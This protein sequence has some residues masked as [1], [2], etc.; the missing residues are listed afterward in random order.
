MTRTEGRSCLFVFFFLSFPL[1]QD[2]YV[3]QT[4]LTLESS[5]PGLLSVVS[6]GPA[7]I[8]NSFLF[9]EGRVYVGLSSPRYSLAW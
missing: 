4:P 5:C 3:A 1:R 7:I 2:L 6:L 8:L 9:K